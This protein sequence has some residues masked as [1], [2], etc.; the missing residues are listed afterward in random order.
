M[1]TG[2]VYTDY[3]STNTTT[4]TTTHTFQIGKTYSTARFGDFTVISRTAKFVTIEN[5]W[6]ETSRVGVRTWQGVEK[7]LPLGRYSMAPVIM[8]DRVAS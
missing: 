3:M 5:K 8:A 4:T 2:V 6:G 7:A 1:T